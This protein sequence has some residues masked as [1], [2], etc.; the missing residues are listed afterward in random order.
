MFDIMHQ[1]RVCIGDTI[2][3]LDL[4]MWLNMTLKA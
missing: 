1:I 3:K 2:G 4:L